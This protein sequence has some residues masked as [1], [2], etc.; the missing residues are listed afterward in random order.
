MENVYVRAVVGGLIGGAVGWVVGVTLTKICKEKKEKK[1]DQW[2]KTHVIN[3]HL[4]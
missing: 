4:S 1:V 3:P 2:N